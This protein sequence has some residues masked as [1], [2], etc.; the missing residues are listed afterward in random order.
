MTSD[1]V[2]FRTDDQGDLEIS[3]KTYGRSAPA[4]YRPLTTRDLRVLART[5][6]RE[7]LRRFI[8]RLRGAA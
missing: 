1:Y 2:Q 6:R 5:V 3:L 7:R 4:T 8:R